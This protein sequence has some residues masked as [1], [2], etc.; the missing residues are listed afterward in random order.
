M[1]GHMHDQRS[2]ACFLY[3]SVLSSLFYIYSCEFVCSNCSCSVIIGFVF[4]CHFHYSGFVLFVSTAV[5]KLYFQV[6]HLVSHFIS[7]CCF[8][9]QNNTEQLSTVQPTATNNQRIINQRAPGAWSYV[10]NQMLF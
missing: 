6:T 9:I 4:C 2:I 7:G 8:V 5:K 10:R 3:N 1:F